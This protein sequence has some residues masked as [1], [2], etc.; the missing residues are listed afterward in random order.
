MLKK[1]VKQRK[2][3]QDTVSTLVTL[4]LLK[5]SHDVCNTYTD[6]GSF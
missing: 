6:T 1:K 5:Y 4:F 2:K 3:I